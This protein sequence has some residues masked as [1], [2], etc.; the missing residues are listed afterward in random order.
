VQAIIVTA[1]RK[2]SPSAEKATSKGKTKKSAAKRSSARRTRTGKSKKKKTGVRARHEF[3]CSRT[4]DRCGADVRMWRSESGAT[5]LPVLPKFRK[6]DIDRSSRSVWRYRAMLPLDDDVLPITLGEGG[7]P[8]HEV[9]IVG[10]PVYVKLEYMQPSGSFK[11]RGA[12]VLASALAA[13]GVRSAV[14]DSSGNAGSSLA[15][16]L[17]VLNVA[18]QLF[19]PNSTPMARL[20]Q[21]AAHGAEIDNSAASRSEASRLAQAALGDA[22]VYAS[23]VYS[24]YFVAGIA[25]MAY[26]IWEDLDGAV[27]D[28]MVVPI[29]NGTLALGL[30]LGFQ[31]LKRAGFAKRLP[32]LFGV[33]A[34]ACAPVY[35]AFTRG[36]VD[37][38]PVAPRDTIA[39]GIRVEDPPR[40]AEVLAAIRDTGGAVL[41]VSDSEI[42]RGQALA[43]NLGWYVE[44]AG[45]AAVS[46][47]VKLD[48][49]IPEG[50]SIV[51]PLTGSGLKQ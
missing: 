40:A 45:A 37:A 25:T 9:S 48:K 38:V 19:V 4:G 16:Y 28:N 26:E 47:V 41:N 18:L 42:L 36:A 43:A 23:H 34:R 20:R 15:A 49:L 33:Q 32:R 39:I 11:D 24:P 31:Q 22:V 51:V 17:S 6:G 10:M 1:A 3:M 50:E 21:A 29:G 2:K 7:T 30:Y 46:G 8:L 35:D 27:P 5:L 13:A 12:A 14:E 44:P